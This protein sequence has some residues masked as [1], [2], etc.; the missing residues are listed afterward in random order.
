MKVSVL[1]KMVPTEEVEQVFVRGANE[2]SWLKAY[3]DGKEKF[4]IDVNFGNGVR[5][6]VLSPT[7]AQEFVEALVNLESAQP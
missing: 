4:Q 2:T 3:W 7:E 6:F 5:S 1:H